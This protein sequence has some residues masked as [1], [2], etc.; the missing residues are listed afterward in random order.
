LSRLLPTPL[1]PPDLEVELEDVLEPELESFW[2]GESSPEFVSEP[3]LSLE[4]GFF[5]MTTKP[6]MTNI[7]IIKT[8]EKSIRYSI[9]SLLRIENYTPSHK[10]YAKYGAC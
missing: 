5:K 1:E 2:E 4:S 10:I 7:R 3:I 9:K 8:T 6:N